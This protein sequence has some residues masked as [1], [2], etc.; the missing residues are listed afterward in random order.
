MLLPAAVIALGLGGL[1]LTGGALAK[2]AAKDFMGSG[3][4]ATV[5]VV[6]SIA[7]TL[8]MVHFLRRLASP[9]VVGRPRA[10]GAGGLLAGD[11]AGSVA[12]PWALCLLLPL[13]AL[14]EALSPAALW[15]ALWPVLIG[16]AIAVGLDSLGRALA[17]DPCR[18][19]RRGAGPARRPGRRG[20]TR[21]S[22]RSTLSCAALGRCEH[23][24]AGSVP[25]VR[26]RADAAQG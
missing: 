26:L 9:A 21:I 10:V 14:P 5:A 13:G 17:A 23:C 19:S 18:R 20:R 8:L 7:T 3:L 15:A 4:A 1:P 25:A 6:S 24:I 16:A 11:G 12:L 22:R 2:Y